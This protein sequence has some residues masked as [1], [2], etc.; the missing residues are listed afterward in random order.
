MSSGRKTDHTHSQRGLWQAS[1][2]CVAVIHQG[3]SSQSETEG[4]LRDDGV[5]W[6]PE[7]LENPRKRPSHPEQG[8][9]RSENPT[10]RKMCFFP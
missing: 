5:M 10:L 2:N 6:C 4:S 8:R 1:L 3:P 7:L 9:E